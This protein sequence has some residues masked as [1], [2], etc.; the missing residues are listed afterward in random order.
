[1]DENRLLETATRAAREAGQLALAQLGDPGR[2][3][4][5]GAR[6][7]VT[8]GIL[9]A[10][11]RI[12]EIIRQEFPGQAI[13]SEELAETPDPQAESLWIVDPLD[14]SLNY[15]RGI[16]FF[17]ISIGFRHNGLHRLGVVYDPCRDELFHAVYRRGAYLNGRRII[18]ARM[19][20]GAAAY[21]EALV[22]TD[23]PA[24]A[25]QR[26]TVAQILRQMAGE[27]VSVQL[28]GS[29]AL[30]LCYIAAGRLDAY[31]HLHL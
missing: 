29:P 4:W 11:D 5:K 13:L 6:D 20:E 16:P 26:T 2:V 14:G 19:A 8:P 28:L 3:T 10:Q 7:V 18:T 23:W 17:S 15:M 1:M 21:R 22:A 12:L 25:G 27:V 31:F 9:K 30:A 24:H